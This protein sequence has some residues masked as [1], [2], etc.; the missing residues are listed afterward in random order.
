MIILIEHS[1]WVAGCHIAKESP[2]NKS[3]EPI[4]NIISDP[5]RQ[6]YYRYTMPVLST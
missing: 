1:L 5:I 2:E 6:L 3:Y 4:D